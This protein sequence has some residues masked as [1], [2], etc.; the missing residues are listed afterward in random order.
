M[1]L[2]RR[3]AAREIRRVL[4][5]VGVARVSHGSPWTQGAPAVL[6]FSKRP[7]PPED[8]F[9]RSGDF[10]AIDPNAAEIPPP[11]RAP[12][13]HRAATP[14]SYG[15]GY[16]QTGSPYQDGYSMSGAASPSSLAPVAMQSYANNT[17]PQ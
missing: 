5:R 7:P 15:F 14:P 8:Y 6:P 12:I 16:G 9:L 11:P 13:F 1:R 2:V 17:G 3:I 10:E 4:S